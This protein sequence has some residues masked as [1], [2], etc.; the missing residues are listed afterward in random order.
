MDLLSLFI[1]TPYN[2]LTT[3]SSLSLHLN[4]LLIFPNSRWSFTFVALTNFLYPRI[5][6]CAFL[7][8]WKI[9]F[10]RRNNTIS[11]TRDRWT[12]VKSTSIGPPASLGPELIENLNFYHKLILVWTNK[13]VWKE[14]LKNIDKNDIIEENLYKLSK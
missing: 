5:F 10:C 14:I 4:N 13:T 11:L 2:W 12:Y 6:L 7:L 8:P 3:S 9:W 1:R